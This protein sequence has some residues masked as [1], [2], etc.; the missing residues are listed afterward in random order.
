MSDV[1][2]AIVAPVLIGWLVSLNLPMEQNFM[3]IALA[4]VVGAAAVML[5]NQ[6]RSDSARVKNERALAG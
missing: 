6:S 3:A 5:V 4:G 1:V 2:V